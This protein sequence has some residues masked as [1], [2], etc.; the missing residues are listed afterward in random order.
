MGQCPMAVSGS[1]KEYLS[2]ATVAA[3]A[4]SCYPF[5]FDISAISVSDSHFKSTF[6]KRHKPDRSQK[7]IL[8]PH[9]VFRALRVQ[10]HELL[11]RDGLKEAPQYT[12]A[13]KEE[14]CQ[15][16]A[17][18]AA[19]LY[20]EAA[21]S[22]MTTWT[23]ATEQR[24]NMENP[25]K[26][27]SR[28][29]KGFSV[30]TSIHDPIVTTDDSDDDEEEDMDNSQVDAIVNMESLHK[31][32][33]Q[34]LR[35]KANPMSQ[36][37]V[38]QS[39]SCSFLPNYLQPKPEVELR[40]ERYMSVLHLKMQAKLVDYYQNHF[41]P[42]FPTS[43]IAPGLSPFAL[44]HKTDDV[45]HGTSTS[46]DS[47]SYSQ[48]DSETVDFGMIPPS[49]PVRF[50]VTDSVFMDLTLTGS[51][52]MDPRSQSRRIP[53][54]ACHK[55]SP[56]HYIVLMNRR[57]GIP[58]AVCALKASTGPPI[59]RIYATQQRVFNQRQAASTKRLGLDWAENLPLFPWAE[60][61]SSGELPQPVHYS[62]YMA[63]GS[64][65]RFTNTPSYRAVFM[66]DGSP[67][68]RVTGRTDKE[69]YE[70]G[71]A[72]ISIKADEDGSDPRFELSIAQGID[73]ALLICFAA[74]FDEVT[75][76]F[77]RQECRKYQR[78]TCHPPP[79]ICLLQHS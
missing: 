54:H 21:P 78:D 9:Q 72:L 25:P 47:S 35:E 65:G 37:K 39:A 77:M 22:V 2:I 26:K 53:S 44:K 5:P 30:L 40:T 66:A 48:G 8:D 62:I 29:K 59:V 73:P 64:D 17:E 19:G 49:S 74:V 70:T 16:G 23:T 79:N 1:D 75:E 43:P 58:L 24:T 4:R 55:K 50:L 41:L 57:S 76:K 12:I 60:I 31:R 38:I 46:S 11:V 68:I 3:G 33:K 34:D 52:G 61:V 51:L 18:S 28:S 27:S 63:S 71:C 67:D 7:C 69:R 6:L 10:T 15:D 36:E 56:A 42:I 13:H 32:S 20:S 45:P 14:C